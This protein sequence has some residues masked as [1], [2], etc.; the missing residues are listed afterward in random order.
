MSAQHLASRFTGTLAPFARSLRLED[1]GPRLEAGALLDAGRLKDLIDRFDASNPGGDRR[2]VV[3]MWSQWH[4]AAVIVPSVV[5]TLLGRVEIPI[6]L[7][8]AAL[9]LHENGCTAGVVLAP[10]APLPASPDRE[11]FAPLLEGH[12]APL[13]D[14]LAKPF[15][16]SPKLLWNNAAGSLAWTVQQ[17]AAQ[18]GVDDEG[19]AEAEAILTSPLLAGGARNAL[20]G[21]LKPSPLVPLD[22][23]QRRICCL[24]YLLPSVADCG[25]YCPLTEQARAVRQG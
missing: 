25:S 11:R 5:G 8:E 10:A 13:V 22:R 19:L 1:G 6:R 20:H 14:S 3:S 24:R 2:A 17:C 12:L 7:G 9:A 15:G 18:A 4:F 21:M 23:C 16:V